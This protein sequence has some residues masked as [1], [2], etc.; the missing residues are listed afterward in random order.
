MFGQ[1]SG[2][3]SI[4]ALLASPM[5]D[6]LFQKAWILSASPVL[7]K[8]STEASKDNEVFVENANCSGKSVDCIRALTAEQVTRYT[9]WDVY[10]NWGMEDQSGLPTRGQFYGAIATVDGMPLNVCYFVENIA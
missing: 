10:P 3:T 2:G 4:F 5:A 8:T 9:P 7:N 6:G 1:S